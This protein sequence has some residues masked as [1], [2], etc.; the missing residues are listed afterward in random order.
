MTRDM[1]EISGKC[2]NGEKPLESVSNGEKPLES[3]SNG[4]KPLESVSN[5]VPMYDKSHVITRTL[6]SLI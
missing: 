5:G 4:E 2:S 3:V 1:R 6:R